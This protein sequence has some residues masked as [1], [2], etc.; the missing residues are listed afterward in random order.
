MFVA[1]GARSRRR[2]DLAATGAAC[3]VESWAQLADQLLGEPKG[4]A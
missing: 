3:V 4:G 1:P 2:A